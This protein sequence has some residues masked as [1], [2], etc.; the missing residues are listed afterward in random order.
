MNSNTLQ[1]YLICFT[2]FLQVSASPQRAAQLFWLGIG[3]S[4]AHPVLLAVSIRLLGAA[5]KCMARHGFDD[6]PGLHAFLMAERKA[7]PDVAAAAKDFDT[8]IEVDFTES[9]FAFAVAALL[10]KGLRQADAVV[11]SIGEDNGLM[12]L[13]HSRDSLFYTLGSTPSPIPDVGR[14]VHRWPA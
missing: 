9:N 6:A 13:A 1:A 8:A 4:Q 11:D 12:G 5:A 2:R 7:R 3:T 10:S 14:L